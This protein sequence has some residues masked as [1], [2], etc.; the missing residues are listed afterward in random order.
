MRNLR[1]MLAG[2]VGAMAV[3]ALNG[4]RSRH[5]ARAP[6]LD[7]LGMEAL[8]RGYRGLGRRPP[9]TTPLFRQALGADL[10]A[11]GLFYAW[12][13]R[14]SYLRAGALGLLAGVGAVL[15]PRRMGLPTRHTARSARTRNLTVA[16]YTA[17]ALVARAASG[18]LA[19]PPE[20]ARL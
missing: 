18:L 4:W 8:R 5:D 16:Y 1:R 19:P 11:N 2:L 17:G 13:A 10:M 3:T 7:Q 20:P 9:G 14:G 12:S 15:L 6:R